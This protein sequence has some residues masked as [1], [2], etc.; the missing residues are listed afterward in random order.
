MIF[1]PPLLKAKLIKRYKRFLFDAEMPGG[2]VITG[3][4]PNTGSMR[5]LTDPGS[6]IYMCDHGDSKTRK[7]RYSLELIEAD[8][9]LVGI[10]TSRPNKLVE[11]AILDGKIGYLA[12]E[13]GEIDPKTS[14]LNRFKSLKREQKYGQNSR[15]DILLED[16]ALGK[17]YV[18]VKNVHFRRTPNLAEFPDSVT[19][20]GA[21]HLY[22][23][24][25]QVKLGHRAIM[26]YLIQRQDCDRFKICAELDPKYGEAFTFAK[27]HGVEAFALRCKI[28]A[29]GIWPDQL[30]DIETC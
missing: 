30:I 29:Q 10:N 16:D 2:S 22:E 17:A 1:D 7:Y 15:I 12:P 4:C 21:K 28:T 8:N 11:A 27:A 26:V 18:E 25:E 19:A 9:T 3:S 24:V 23:L 14:N 5:G 6:T 20:R 13:T